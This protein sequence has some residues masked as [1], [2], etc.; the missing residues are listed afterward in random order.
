MADSHNTTTPS[1]RG[2]AALIGLAGV[3][4]ASP[5]PVA[6]HFEVLEDIKRLKEIITEALDEC[7]E[8]ARELDARPQD[9]VRILAAWEA[10]HEDHVR[11]SKLLHYAERKLFSLLM[12]QAGVSI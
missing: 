6:A 10:A 11:A 2:I 1:R 7:G 3:A 5:A 9:E 8:L 12:A 4:V